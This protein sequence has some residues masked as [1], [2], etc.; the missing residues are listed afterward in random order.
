MIGLSSFEKAAKHLSKARR[1]AKNDELLVLHA[2]FGHFYREKG[3]LK[4][5]ERW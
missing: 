3:E 4:R 5:A 2:R 1:L